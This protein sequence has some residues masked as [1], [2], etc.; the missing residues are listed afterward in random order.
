MTNTRVSLSHTKRSEEEDLITLINE[1]V[2]CKAFDKQTGKKTLCLSINKMQTY[3]VSSINMPTFKTWMEKQIS[4][5]TK[6]NYLSE[7]L[8][9]PIGDSVFCRA[10]L[11]RKRS[12]TGVLLKRLDDVG[13]VDP[14][15]ALHSSGFVVVT[16]SLSILLVP[17]PL[18]SLSLFCS[19]L[20][21]MF[22][23]VSLLA[24]ECIL[25]LLRGSRP[26]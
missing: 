21:K 3:T 13:Q 5:F 8:G 1:L 11:D 25:P 10:V 15:V 4:K 20:I 22:K 2:Q 17:Y 18:R 23:N 12:E 6:N 14:Q 24:Q 16:V 7:I 26:S 19:Y 9:I